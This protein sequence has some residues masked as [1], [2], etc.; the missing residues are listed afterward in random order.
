MESRKSPVARAEPKLT[1]AAEKAGT[2]I[3]ELQSRLRGDT[4]QVIDGRPDETPEEMEKQLREYFERETRPAPT[5]AAPTAAA[6]HDIRN[7][8]LDGVVERILREWGWQPD[9]KSN[10][11]ENEVIERLIARVLERLNSVK[12]AKR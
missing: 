3:R 10:P 4:A 11:L 1:E 12:S 6:L 7:R 9:G 2:L 5:T 8:V